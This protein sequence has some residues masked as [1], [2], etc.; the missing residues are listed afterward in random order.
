[1]LSL[2]PAVLSLGPAVLSLGAAVLSLDLLHGIHA[3][4]LGTGVVPQ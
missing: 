1:V 2:G 4:R 3:L